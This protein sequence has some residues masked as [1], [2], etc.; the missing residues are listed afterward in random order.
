MHWPLNLYYC[1]NRMSRIQ[2]RSV[3]LCPR[4]VRLFLLP[5]LA[6]PLFIFLS[7]SH[8]FLLRP[9]SPTDSASHQS[10]Q[11]LLSMKYLVWEGL[12]A[13]IA[14][15]ISPWN[16]RWYV[17]P[18]CLCACALTASDAGRWC[19]KSWSVWEERCS[20]FRDWGEDITSSHLTVHQ[21]DLTRL[22]TRK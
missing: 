14:D 2:I 19:R 7:F 21:G 10:Q 1:S 9:S 3:A 12:C 22:S 18:C 4:Y 16:N 8:L 13:H 20:G 5:D 6:A 11:C 15:F 17:C